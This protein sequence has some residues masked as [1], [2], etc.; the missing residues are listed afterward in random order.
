MD[1]VRFLRTPFLQNTSGRLLLKLYLKLQ[2]V[3]EPE[4]EIENEPED[5]I[6]NEPEVKLPLEN[7]VCSEVQDITNAI[8]DRTGFHLGKMLH[9]TDICLVFVI[10]S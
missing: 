7:E 9:N 5:K 6:E 8:C 2:D 1:F 3:Y 4:E 10:K